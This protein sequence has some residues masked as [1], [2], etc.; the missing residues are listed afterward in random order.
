MSRGRAAGRCHQALAFR[1][2]TTARTP[3]YATRSS[4][5]RRERVGS[6][7]QGGHGEHRL[8]SSGSGAAVVRV[9]AVGVERVPDPRP[10]GDEQRCEDEKAVDARVLGQ[11]VE[12][13]ATATTKTRSKKSS[14]QVAWRSSPSSS[15]V[16]SR[17][18]LHATVSPCGW[19]GPSGP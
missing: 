5:C 2:T 14:S 9:E 6:P 7:R 16:R 18:G 17:G 10:H 8:R 11:P 15:S 19:V 1:R 12:S 4:L 3:A 13:W